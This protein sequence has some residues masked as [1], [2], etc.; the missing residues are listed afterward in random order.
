MVLW[1]RLRLPMQG[2]SVQSLVGELRSHTPHGQKTETLNRRNIVTN[3]MKTLK[4]VHI[5]KSL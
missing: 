2:V 1:L 3:S 5:K 4:M